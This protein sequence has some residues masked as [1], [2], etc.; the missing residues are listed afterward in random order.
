MTATGS[1]GEV[2]RATGRRLSPLGE[3]VD[4]PTSHVRL[5]QVLATAWLVTGQSFSWP[6]P[7]LSPLE[8][9][10]ALPWRFGLALASTALCAGLVLSRATRACAGG[11]AALIALELF[12]SRTWF[13]HN[14]LFVL[15]LLLMV[16]LASRRHAWLPRVQVGLVFLVAAGDKAL[17]P[18]WRDG[19]FV[20]SFLEELSRFGLMWAPGGRVGGTNLLAGWLS[21]RVGDG[22]AAGL[23]VIVVEGLLAAA[24][25]ANVRSGAWLNAAFHVG[26]FALTGG[27]MGQFFFAGLAA[28]LLLVPQARQPGAG[29]VVA[30]TVLL[31]GPWTHHLLPLLVFAVVGA[32]ALRTRGRHAVGSAGA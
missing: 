31:A 7:W 22:V 30:V 16:A 6:A 21:A 19:R 14:R 18:A 32:L 2:L 8:G 15:A 27:T 24:F 12:A 11:L 10:P 28:S 17:A 25:F 5:A 26:V 23:A 9:V 4:L 20:T 29:H 3:H 13:A 1:L